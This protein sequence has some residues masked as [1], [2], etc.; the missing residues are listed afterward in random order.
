MKILQYRKCCCCRLLSW[1]LGHTRHLSHTTQLL[2]SLRVSTLCMKAEALVWMILRC[3]LRWRNRGLSYLFR[4]KKTIQDHAKIFD[5]LGKLPFPGEKA[6]FQSEN[7]VL[8]RSHN[9]RTGPQDLRNPR[10]TSVAQPAT[11]RQH[12]SV[13]LRHS[14]A[15]A[16][17]GRPD[18]KIPGSGKG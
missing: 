10:A 2:K 3:S 12:K 15:A 16:G 11:P 7:C 13:L 4:E 9:L 14:M 18:F 5:A 1:N 6:L 8:Q 17:Q